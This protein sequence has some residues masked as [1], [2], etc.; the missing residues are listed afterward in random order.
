SLRYIPEGG[1]FVITNGD[2][3]FNRALYG[4]NTGYRTEAGDLPEFALYM[5]GMGGNLRFALISEEQGKWISTLENIKTIYRPG[6]MIYEISDRKYLGNGKLNLHVLS[7]ADKEGFII[8]VNFNSVSNNS[9]KLAWVFGG[10]TG[11]RFSREG[12][13]GAD[14]ESVFYLHP[15][16]CL[17]NEYVIHKEGFALKYGSGKVAPTP[18]KKKELIGLFPKG[19]YKI[20]N[21]TKASDNNPLAILNSKA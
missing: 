17:D 8:K 19:S 18:D 7:S 15:E 4:T 9:L 1:D 16:N 13:I 2:R 6:S 20:V 3:K 10:A 11:R 5:P 14:P 21:A 12:D